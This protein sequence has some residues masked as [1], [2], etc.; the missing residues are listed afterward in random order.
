MSIIQNLFNKKVISQ[1]IVKTDRAIFINF[2]IMRILY[3]LFYPFISLTILLFYKRIKSVNKP[4]AIFNRTV[5]ASNHAASFMDPLVVATSNRAVVYFM[6]RSDVFTTI[7][8][9]F[10]WAFHMLPIYRQQDGVDTKEKNAEVF[11][12]CTDALVAKKNLLIYPEGLTDD[13]FIRRLKP[14][15]KGAVRI[16]FIALESNN[17]KEK[18]YVAAIGCNYMYPNAMR[19]EVLISNSE[20]ICLN[21]YRT[22]YLENP[23]KVITE[24]TLKVE[25]LMKAQITHVEVEVFAV[26]HEQMMCISG[27][28]MNYQSY[29][30]SL[31]L[32]ERW[33]Y[34]KK[35]ADW[36]NQFGEELPSN[37]SE[38]KVNL[39]SYFDKLDS[40]NI[41]DS[42]LKTIKDNS[43][44]KTGF[45][46]KA[47]FLLPFAILGFLHFFLLYRFVKNFVEK[48]FKRDVFWGSTK[49]ILGMFL[50]GLINLPIVLFIASLL[51]LPF[52]MGL[53]YFFSTSI[54]WL[55]FVTLKLYWNEFVRMNKLSEINV[56]EL[57]QQRLQLEN[58]MNEI[59]PNL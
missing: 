58:Q 4:K 5:Y 38:F 33:K 7:S 43:Y 20:P 59:V 25:E 52:W 36:L 8:K 37:I 40:K 24:L 51:S 2:A 56:D 32:E 28:G 39:K 27:K 23:H 48:K 6:T 21:D 11:Q 13:V 46:L 3:I 31:S 9:P 22:D 53:I 57:I 12:K 44:S 34:S 19:S 1:L 49:M 41:L 45:F 15:K 35:L 30:K 17:W 10:L 14:I 16:G 26:F 50:F 54:Y 29:D 55:A 18:V 42:D 47:L